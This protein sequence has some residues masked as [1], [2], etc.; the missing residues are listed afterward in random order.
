MAESPAVFVLQG[1]EKVV[2]PFIDQDRNEYEAQIEGHDSGEQ[3]SRGPPFFGNPVWLGEGPDLT[4]ERPGSDGQTGTLTHRCPSTSGDR[5]QGDGYAARASGRTK[6]SHR[7][8]FRRAVR[9]HC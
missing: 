6:S 7:R 9:G 8:T 5:P 2:I 1:V 4:Q 3:T